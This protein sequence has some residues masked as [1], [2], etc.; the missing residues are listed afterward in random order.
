MCV[1]SH[2]TKG[3]EC[4]KSGRQAGSETGYWCYVETAGPR[5]EED[6]EGTQKTFLFNFYLFS[7][8]HALFHTFITFISVQW[9]RTPHM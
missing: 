4:E 6:S 9:T 7:S 5:E 2:T 8:T 1:I 3:K